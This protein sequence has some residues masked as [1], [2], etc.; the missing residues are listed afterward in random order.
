MEFLDTY[1]KQICPAL[2]EYLH[3]KQKALNKNNQW[4]KDVLTRIE[5]FSTNGKMIRGSLV[6][7]A[8][9]MFGRK[10]NQEALS[11]AVALELTQSGI[12]IHDDIIDQDTLRRGQDSM[13]VQYKKIGYQNKFTNDEHFGTSMAV[14]VGDVGFFLSFELLHLL[15]IDA[16]IKQKIVSVYTNEMQIVGL[17][18]MQDVYLS[19]LKI[20]DDIKD[21]KQLYIQKTGRYTFS[22]PL[23]IGA[24]IANQNKEILNQLEEFGEKLGL[25]FQIVDDEISL[26]GK[27]SSSGKPIGTDILR[28]NKTFYQFY[29]F[30]KADK[31][32]QEELAVIFGNAQ[33]TEKEITYIHELIIK[34]DIQDLVKKEAALLEKDVLMSIEQLPIN[35]KHKRQLQSL[36]SFCRTRN[37]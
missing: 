14:C 28:N 10:I 8:C 13:Y 6:L 32:E 19:N 29:L 34:Y 21:I 31:K 16:T 3:L 27:A 20:V 2:V 22:M 26:F 35:S 11:A 30:K 7:L 9:E 24:L 17:A 23:M 25:L 12:L 15:K 1:K 37:K 33:S 36:V 5:K 18:E 4:S